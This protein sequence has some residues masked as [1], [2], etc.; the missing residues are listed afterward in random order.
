M[1]LAIP[2]YMSIVDNAENKTKTLSVSNADNKAQREM[3]G[4]YHTH[5]PN[6]EDT[7]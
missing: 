5:H 2:P 7:R 4:P 3:W 1:K 6:P